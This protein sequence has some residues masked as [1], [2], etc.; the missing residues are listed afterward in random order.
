MLSS[1]E[2][3]LRFFRRAD[4]RPPQRFRRGVYLIPGLF[5][6]GNMWCGYACIVNAMRGDYETAAP[7]IG[8]AYLLDA[9]DGRIARLT[10]AESE[11]GLQL[12]SLAD[13]VSFGIA[14]AVLAYAWGLSSLGR[15]GWAVGFLFVA[16]AAMRLARFN[17]QSAGGGDKRYFVGIPSPAAAGVVA[18]TVF[19][20]P[21]GLDDYRAALPAIAVVLIPAVMMV[22]TIRYR[23]FKDLDLR[24][25]RS[26]RVLILISVGIVAIWT[27]PRGV[28]LALSYAYLAS[29]LI[30]YAISRFRR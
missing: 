3:R 9:L 10:G 21:S 4:D 20:Y 1:P 6:M 19:F 17:I 12:D 22:S 5:T 7:F 13:V 29:G 11:F 2:G 24:S 28:L 8:F 16:C 30:G 25:R 15:L 14:P 23:S 26:F 18:A 27:H